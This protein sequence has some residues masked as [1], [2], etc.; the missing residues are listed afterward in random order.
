[1][2]RDLPNL[3][4]LRVFAATAATESF[5][6]AADRLGVTAGAVSQRIK[7]LEAFLDVPLFQRHAQGVTLTEAGRRYAQRVAPAVDQLAAATRE[8]SAG[9]GA[10]TVRVTILPALAQLWLG[11][12]LDD[13]HAR[14]PNTS[15]E[16]WADATVIDMRSAGFDI[17]IRYGR[18]PFSGCDHRP[19]LVDEMVPVAAPSL[20]AGPRDDRGLPAGA[21]LMLDTYWAQDFD[22]WL[23]VTGEPRVTGQVVQTFSLYS[24]VVEATLNGRGFM[25]G[26]SSLVDGLLRRGQLVALSGRRVPCRNQFHLLTRSGAPLSEATEAF[27]GWLADQAA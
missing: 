12:R 13:F 20:A 8:I 7:A 9:A 1:M 6:L 26:H 25:M 4:W 15:V 16:I 23:A 10:R 19:L 5:A 21:P 27:V 18:P 22:D 24:M 2:Q 11:P 14:H 17:A 3:D